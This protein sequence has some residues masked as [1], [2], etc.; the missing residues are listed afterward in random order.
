MRVL[1]IRLCLQVYNLLVGLVTQL[2]G[3]FRV[4][5]RTSAAPL[6]LLLTGNFYSDTW[7]RS[8]LAPLAAS[9]RVLQIIMVTSKPLPV[10]NKVTPYYPGERL[11]KIF[12]ADV[13]RLITFLMLAFK[14]KPDL[15]GG[16]HLL[17]N[18]LLALFAGRCVSAKTLYVCGGGIRE[19]RGGGFESESRIF[20]VL[21]KASASIEQQLLKAVR[22]FDYIFVRGNRARDFFLAQGVPETALHIVTAGIDQAAFNVQATEKK[23]DLVFVG[24][25]SKVKR[26]HLV[27]EALGELKQRGH[28]YRLLVVGDGP[29]R[30]DMETLADRLGVR[31]QIQFVGWTNDVADYLRQAK[32]FILTSSSEGMSQAMLQAMFCGLPALVT[33]VG[34][35]SDA[36][37]P[38]SNGLLIH[39]D[40]ANRV[41]IAKCIEKIL[42]ER[43]AASMG[44]AA[45][46]LRTR[47]SSEA[48]AQR[49]SAVI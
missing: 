4:N 7:I 31:A 36:I 49:I 35:L 28:G 43:D 33:D 5:E 29:D 2:G 40:E 11:K 19:V 32:V 8:Q 10:V 6:T 18:G 3:K 39:T 13:A 9:D 41:G 30:S 16:Y 22:R 15:V 25:I 1:M 20:G 26:L 44:R 23:Y 12:G 21:Q 14:L 48:V 38:G 37:I 17:L 47:Y 46:N 24:R 27:I 42:V 34:D 45:S